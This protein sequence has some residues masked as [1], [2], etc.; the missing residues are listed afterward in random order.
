VSAYLP[1]VFMRDRHLF[2][3]FYTFEGASEADFASW[4]SVM[5]W[6]FKKVSGA[7][8][9]SLGKGQQGWRTVA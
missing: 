5:L 4:H 8:H 9:C 3:A 1:L 7:C 2:D 6:F